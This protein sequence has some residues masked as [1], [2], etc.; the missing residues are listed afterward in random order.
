[1]QAKLTKSKSIKSLAL[2]EAFR[3]LYSLD[4]KNGYKRRTRVDNAQRQLNS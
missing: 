2:K 1:M 3:E 4:D